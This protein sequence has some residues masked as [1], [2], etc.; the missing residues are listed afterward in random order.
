[1]PAAAIIPLP[2]VRDRSVAPSLQARLAGLTPL[3][4][5]SS[6]DTLTSTLPLDHSALGD[7][8]TVT[9]GSFLSILTVA[10]PVPLL[11]ATASTEHVTSCVPAAAI[12]ALPA[13]SG[14]SVAPSL[15]ARLPALTPLPPVSSVATLTST[16]PFDHSE[17]GDLVTVTVGSVRSILTTKVFAVST[18]LALS[19]AE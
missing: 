4:P 6:V 5:V 17:L 14:R 18:L 15:Q 7:L 1:M 12:V 16:L 19:V 11:P 8:V 2:A 3:P 13:V 10:L 9:V